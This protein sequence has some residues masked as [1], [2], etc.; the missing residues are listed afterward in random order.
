M[1]TETQ[2]ATAIID[3]DPAR[4]GAWM[5]AH[6]AGQYRDGTTC[7]GL[8]RDGQLVA[9]AM[10]DYYNGASIFA[11]I[12]VTGRL[13]REWLWFICYYPFVQLQCRVILG[14]VSSTNT[15]SRRFVEKFGFTCQADIANAEPAGSTLIYTLRKEDCRFLQRRHH[16]QA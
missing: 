3:Q 13:T 14:L 6:G 5:H 11:H 1:S 12:A 16:V 15:R 9:G 2:Q 7:L 8:E 4:V 10:Y